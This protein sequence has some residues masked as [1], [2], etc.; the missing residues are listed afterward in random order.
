MVRAVTSKKR[1]TRRTQFLDAAVRVIARVGARS[2]RVEDVA[3]EAGASTPLVY[4]YFDGRHDL[5]AAAFR[6]ANA[7]LLGTHAEDGLGGDGRE[8]LLRYLLFEIEDDEETT[9]IWAFWSELAATA[10]FDE[11]LRTPINDAYG[12][13]VDRVVQIVSEGQDDGSID[14]SLDPHVT[15][16]ALTALMDGL[17]SRWI[18]GGMDDKRAEQ[19][20]TTVIERTLGPRPA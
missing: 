3:R 5:L 16:D 10:V 20:A 9:Q 13:W 15:A 14:P 12:E 7:Q 1:E 6:H 17:G 2:L 19:V 18:L 4:Y 11:A 8:R